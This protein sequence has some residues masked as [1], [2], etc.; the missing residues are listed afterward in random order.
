MYFGHEL[1][2]ALL[3]VAAALLMLVAG[4]SKRTLEW[5]RE[6]RTC[7]ACGLPHRHCRCRG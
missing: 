5:R 7:P 1:T 3:T 2:L 6:E 4:F